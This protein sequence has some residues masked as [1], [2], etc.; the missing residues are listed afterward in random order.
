MRQQLMQAAWDLCIGCELRR[1]G[2]LQCQ[3]SYQ[4]WWG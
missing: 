4:A 1:E 3:L 2:Q